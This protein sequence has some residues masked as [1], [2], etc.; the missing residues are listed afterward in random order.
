MH[1]EVYEIVLYLEVKKKSHDVDI[2]VELV[3]KRLCGDVETVTYFT[4]E[5]SKQS[6]SFMHLFTY[7]HM[8]MHM[9]KDLHKHIL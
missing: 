9:F 2:T 3:S 7:L 1:A 4:E 5:I 6:F 8:Q